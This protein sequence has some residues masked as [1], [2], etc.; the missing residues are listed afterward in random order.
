LRFLDDVEIRHPRGASGPGFGNAKNY[1][2]FLHSA[3]DPEVWRAQ[4]KTPPNTE[5]DTLPKN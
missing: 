4:N 3:E 1:R 2:I 5:H